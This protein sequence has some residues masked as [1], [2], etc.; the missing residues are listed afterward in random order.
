MSDI[1]HLLAPAYTIQKIYAASKPPKAEKSAGM[2]G[3]GSWPSTGITHM[4]PDKAPTTKAVNFLSHSDR[5]SMI[6][7]G[8]ATKIAVISSIIK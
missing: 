6:N 7:M 8:I 2:Y 5:L 4:T 3:S 1:T